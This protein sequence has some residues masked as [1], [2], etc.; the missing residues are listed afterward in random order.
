MIDVYIV[1]S[2]SL[3]LLIVCLRR[4]RMPR[5]KR[6]KGL[7]EDDFFLPSERKRRFFQPPD[8]SERADNVDTDLPS[9]VQELLKSRAVAKRKKDWAVA[10]RIRASLKEKGYACADKNGQQV[11]TKVPVSTGPALGADS[12]KRKKKMRQKERRKQEIELQGGVANATNPQRKTLAMGIT[13]EDLKPGHGKEVQRGKSVEVM[14]VGRFNDKNGKIFDRTKG[15][16][17]TFRLGAGEVIK[18]WDIGMVG[19]KQGGK[20]R[21]YVPPH[22]GYG[23]KASGKIPGNSHLCFDVTVVRAQK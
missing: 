18:G 15:K 16:P 19:M 13:V 3:A 10:D 17:F 4:R 5:R 21:I 9:D 2:F 6:K 7:D 20:R 8:E 22:A 23:K 14:Y 12:K 11:V 1:H